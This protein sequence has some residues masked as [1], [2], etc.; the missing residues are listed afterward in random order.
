MC[1][2]QT[3]VS[4]SSTESEI[5]FLDAGLRL[6]GIT[7][8]DLWDLIVAV[9]GNTTQNHDRTG[10]LAV[11]R[12]ASHERYQETQRRNSE[13]EQNGTLSERQR[14]QIL[15]CCQAE[16]RKH[17]FQA[18]YDRRD[19]PKLNE[20]IESHRGEIYRAHQ[21]DER[22]EISNFF[23]NNYWNKIGIFVKLM[24]KVSMK[25]KN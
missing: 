21:G 11:C 24:R 2:K 6:D 19:I 18:D 25:W 3:L 8:L 12:D 14:E 5:L 22:D 10:K 1:K 7:A 20:V 16:I 15:V 9:L 23:M 17:E 13:S 4:H